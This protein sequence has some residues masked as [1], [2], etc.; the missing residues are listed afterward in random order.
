MREITTHQTNQCNSAIRVQAHEA[1]EPG[2]APTAYAIAW[3]TKEGREVTTSLQFQNGPI[4]DVGTNGLTNE[5][6]IA[7]LIDRLEG[8][9]SG[10][11]ACPE[12]AGALTHLRAAMHRLD[13]RTRARRARG[14]EGTHEV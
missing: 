2:N 7:V 9:Q 13:D 5:V 8:F 12:N 11:Y 14:V 6:L 1:A 10:P 3:T 4:P